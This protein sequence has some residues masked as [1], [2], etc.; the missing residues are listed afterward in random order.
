MAARTNA[1]FGLAE[2]TAEFLTGSSMIRCFSVLV[3]GKTRITNGIASRQLLRG[4]RIALV[5]RDNGFS[6]INILHQIVDRFP[7]I[8]LV[9]QEGTLAKGK[10]IVGGSKNFLNNGRIRHIGGSRQLIKRQAGNAVHQHMAF[11]PPVERISPLV[12]LVGRGMNAQSAVWVSFG[13]V[14]RF[15]LIL[16]KGFWIVLL[17]V[18]RNGGGVQADKG[19]VHNAQVVEFFH[20]SRHDLLQFS[21]VQLFEETV[22]SPVRRQRLHDVKAAV[23]GNEPVVVQI[24]RQIGDLRETLALHDNKSADHGF[25]WKA[26]PPSCRPGQC[27]IQD[28]KELVIERSGTLGC[29]Q[30]YILN[31][32]LSVDSG[33]PLSG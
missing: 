23:M 7:I 21:V 28:A 9:A 32:F 25:F 18:C 30:C 29:E 33:Q 31:D 22:I 6:L 15:E 13:M 3:H 8:A 26:S 1:V 2:G 27:E 17:C 24:I 4:L 16:G 14:F 5:Q 12:M 20:L 10:G 19:S 11:V